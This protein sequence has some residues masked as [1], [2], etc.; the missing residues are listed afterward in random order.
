MAIDV[1]AGAKTPVALAP[2]SV[3]GTGNTDDDGDGAKEIDGTGSV[4]WYSREQD[5]E[6]GGNQGLRIR[7]TL[8]HVRIAITDSPGS[9]KGLSAPVLEL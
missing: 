6:N 8:Y 9:C 5:G 3:A 4:T 1:G 7:P 2:P